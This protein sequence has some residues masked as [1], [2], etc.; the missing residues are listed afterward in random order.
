MNK[1][2]L[3]WL[4][5]GSVLLATACSKDEAPGGG[6]ADP[7]ASGEAVTVSFTISPEGKSFATRAGASDRS[8]H[9]PEESKNEFAQI[10]DGS[11]ARQLIYAVY[12]DDF[13]LLEQYGTNDTDKN[14]PHYGQTILD[15]NEFPV[16]INL[17]LMR[18]Q[19]YNIVF[20]AQNADCTAYDTD[21]LTMVEVS[22]DDAANNDELRDA[23]CH[24]E[25][26]TV[27]SDDTREVVLTRPLA[28][29]NVGTAGYNYEFDKLENGVT[30][31]TESE[32]AYLYSKI[33]LKG[34]A[35]Y[36]D[37]L[38]NKVLTAEDREKDEYAALKGKQM[39]A[40][41]TYGWARIP[42]YI[43]YESLPAVYPKADLPSPAKQSGESWDD[44][45]RRFRE[46]FLRVKV[47]PELTSEAPYLPYAGIPDKTAEN[48]EPD[49]ET[50]KYLSM[51]YVLVP[52]YINSDG[53]GYSTT[54]ESVT[55]WVNHGPTDEDATWIGPAGSRVT[56]NTVPV[57]RN[58]RTNIFGKSL[59]T[60]RYEPII[61]L[62]PNFN[63]EYNKDDDKPWTGDR[64]SSNDPDENQSAAARQ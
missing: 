55:V 5:A 59:M 34:V 2:L 19:T 45:Y 54:L 48:P 43:N 44:Y 4:A 37:V 41:V 32:Q 40:D 17:R 56:A 38:R 29:I 3:G 60:F 13:K 9:Y 61:K 7:Y 1:K 62:E 26:F 36:I 49:T 8:V 15:D 16:T 35:K 25:T 27:T 30:D 51:C 10:S 57:Q 21:D 50:F 28:Q 6:S 46:Q 39:T 22:Y 52:D 31:W 64:D 33:E 24:T 42:A 63:G 23:F 20:W 53:K 58:W 14:G 11:K 18:R 12:T 47:Y